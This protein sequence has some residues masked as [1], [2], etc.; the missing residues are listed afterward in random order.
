MRYRSV[1][2]FPFNLSTI[3]AVLAIIFCNCSSSAQNR[4][5]TLF[6]LGDSNGA[7]QTGWVEQL[8]S[9]RPED[10]ILNYSKSGNTI[11]FDN[12]DNP[13]LNTLRQI[14]TYLSDAVIQ[15][16]GTPIDEVFINLG[17]NDSKAVFDDLKKEV[18]LNLVYLVDQ[19]QQFP[20]QQSIPP[21]I[22][23][24]SPPPYGPD[25]V[26]LEKY[27]GGAA[28]VKQLLPA[29]MEVANNTDSHFIDIHTLLK[30]DYTQLA[31][32]GIH[33]HAEGQL[34]IAQ[35]IQTFLEK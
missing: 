13:E 9:L 11:G 24:I 19:I 5:R 14:N 3:C 29:F 21:R 35:A 30:E 4:P 6:I 12:L 22:T 7:S 2:P 34:R 27:H 10:R 31:P 33:M 17:T 23:I 25:S 8:R 15:L 18:P 26:M 16:D 1:L 32:D 20:L 28:R